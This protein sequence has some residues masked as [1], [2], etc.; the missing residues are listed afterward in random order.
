ME[1]R[2]RHRLGQQDTVVIHSEGTVDYMA[3]KAELL[4]KNLPCYQKVG[5]MLPLH[6]FGL[7]PKARG[8]SG[9]H[10]AS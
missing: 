1:S 8:Q 4:K 7:G 10:E 2:R 3:V 9:K 5:I 6:Y